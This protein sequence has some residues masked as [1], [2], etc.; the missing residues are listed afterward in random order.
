MSSSIRNAP[1]AWFQRV[2]WLGIVT[3]LA[4]ATPTLLVP[5]RML[6]FSSL[7]AAAPLLWPRLAAW[8]LIL[9]S[10][11][12]I[13]AAVDPT[14]YRTV[15]WLAVGSRLA[16]VLFF[17]TQSSDYRMLGAV[18]LVFL[19]PEGILLSLASRAEH[20]LEATRTAQ[21]AAVR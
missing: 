12:Y 10:A 6:A 20:R 2:L 4:L 7:P 5:E 15:A 17:L 16:G 8:L 18:D 9:L 14:R 1:L 19:V 11:F 3:N 21:P 13:P